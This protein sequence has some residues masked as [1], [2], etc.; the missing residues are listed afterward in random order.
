VN[1]YLLRDAPGDADRGAAGHTWT[2]VDGGLNRPELRDRWQGAWAELGI[3]PHTIRRIV[4]THMHPDHFGLAGW[5][6]EQTGAGVYL[7]PREIDIARHTWLEDITP[8]RAAVVARYM[9]SAG[10]DP[11]TAA[12]ITGQQEYLRTLTYPHPRALIALHPGATL[13][14]GGRYWTA[15]HAPGH[16]DGQLIFYSAADRLLLCGDHVLQRITPN[17][18]LWPTTEPDPLTR[19]LHSL[20]DLAAL[21]VDLALP[22][23]HGPLLDWRG[24]IAELQSHH[25]ARLDAIYAAV[26]A[27]ESEPL[28]PPQADQRAP[29]PGAT[30]LAVSYRVFNY[31]RFSQHEVRFAVAETLAHLETLAEQG[32]LHRHET[33]AARLYRTV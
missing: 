32:R 28:A 5:L 13:R 3:A 7:S 14:M 8:A 6:Q 21:E 1:C 4:L 16:A 25:A 27:I 26:A 2:I 9:H 17:I 31:D 29:A 24:R 23:H 11:A 22:G 15:I 19:Y 30:A 20:A 33:P 12:V 18:G 10:V